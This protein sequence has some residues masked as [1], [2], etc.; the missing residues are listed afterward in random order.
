MLGQRAH[1]EPATIICWR[2][3]RRAGVA[4]QFP[5]ASSCSSIRMCVRAGRVRGRNTSR[6]RRAH[7]YLAET[8]TWF[9]YGHSDDARATFVLRTYVVSSGREA[10]EGNIV[11]S[12]R[13]S[14][15][16]CEGLQPCIDM[17]ARMTHHSQP[18][19][20]SVLVVYCY[21]SVRHTETIGIIL[22]LKVVN[23]LYRLCAWCSR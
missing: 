14:S 10:F 8:C 4:G 12:V 19:W 18:N 7:P 1:V 16:C 2:S 9:A 15:V 13:G 11:R 6:I 23:C 5:R 21:L 20:M 22:Y 3:H 17:F